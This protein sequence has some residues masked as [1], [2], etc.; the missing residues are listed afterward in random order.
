MTEN[1]RDHGGGLDAAVARWGGVRTDWID[2]STGI[3]PEPYP[4]GELTSDAWTAL[5]DRAAQDRLIKA[6]RQF[7]DVPHEAA[8]LAAPGA[9]ALIAKMPSLWPTGQVQIDAPTYNEHAAAFEAAGWSMG[10]GDAMIAVHPNNPDGRFWGAEMLTAPFTIIDESF[11]DIAP[12]RSLIRL[13]GRPGTVVLKSFGKFWGLAGLRLGFAIGDP[14][15]IAALAEQLGPWPVSG[16]ALEIGA[17]ALEDTAWTIAT[18]Q[19]LAKDA[20]RLDA[21]MAPH[22]ALIGGTDLFRLYDVGDAQAFQRRLAAAHIWSRIF[23]YSSSWLRLGLPSSKDWNRL[24][25][26]L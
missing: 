17:R 5:P 22:G 15:M 7:W 21:L 26:A 16:P 1:Q 2:L 14:K 6:A 12:D 13:A 3:N 9:S 19:R 23:P 25:A 4:L 24:D 10:A 8:V 11:C 20:Q 18:R